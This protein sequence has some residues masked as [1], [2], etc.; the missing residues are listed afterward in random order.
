VQRTQHPQPAGFPRHLGHPLSPGT[1]TP[2]VR[3]V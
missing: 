2:L 3:P 1:Q